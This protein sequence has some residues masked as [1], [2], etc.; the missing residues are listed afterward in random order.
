[1]GVEHLNDVLPTISAEE[2]HRNNL[3]AFQVG[4]RAKHELVKG[5][6]ALSRAKGLLDDLNCTSIYQY[7]FVNFGYGHTHTDECLR[8]AEALEKLPGCVEKFRTGSICWSSVQ[9]ITRIAEPGTESTWLDFARGKSVRQ[10]QAEVENAIEKK[11]KT[12]R[13]DAT[14]LPNLTVTIP[15]R[16]TREEFGVLQ[17]AF[18]KVGK[19]LRGGMGG[20]GRFEPKD[21]VLYMARRF[22]ETDPAGTPKGRIELEDPISTLLYEVCTE[23]GKAHFMAR[24][25]PVEVSPE[26]IEKVK[27]EAREVTISPEETRP[28]HGAPEKARRIDRKNTRALVR[29]AILRD[30]LRCAN[31]FCENSLGLQSNHIEERAKGG[32][33]ELANANIFCPRCHACYHAGLLDVRRAP[34]GTPIVTRRGDVIR[35]QFEEETR[36]LP[37]NP[38]VVVVGPGTPQASGRLEGDGVPRRLGRVLRFIRKIKDW[39]KAEAEERVAGA[40]SKLAEIGKSEPREDEVITMALY[41]TLEVGTVRKSKPGGSPPAA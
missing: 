7:A 2:I 20:E 36:E 8:V 4:N 39:E 38:K 26:S 32:R 40:L 33:T 24:E 21:I 35:K 6:L 13:K 34:D 27:G 9:Q 10:V 16:F 41:G 37:S 18:A 28:G 22:L 19:E 25:G 14:G 23:C 12:P 29:K 5:L 11:R 15:L 3:R 1:M 17:K 31:P 30:G